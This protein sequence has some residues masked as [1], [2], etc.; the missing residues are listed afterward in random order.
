LRDALHR[1]LSRKVKFGLLHERTPGLSA[2]Y[3]SKRRAQWDGPETIRR[4]QLD[5]LNHLL[6]HAQRSSPYYARTLAGLTAIERL[7]DLADLPVLERA[8][9]Q[10]G[11]EE[12][13]VQA[14][15][16]RLHGNASGGS[17]GEPV[18]FY[19]GE[20]ALLHMRAGAYVLDEMAGWRFGAR[21][22]HLWGA[23]RDTRATPARRLNWFLRNEIWIDAFRMESEALD[24]YHAALTRA[25]PEILVAYA[26]AAALLA[27]HLRDGRLEPT[28]PTRAI[29][30][31]AEPL[32]AGTRRRIREVFHVPVFNRYGSRE[33]GP[34][35]MECSAARGMHVN[36][37][38]LV[39]EV[40][41]PGTGTPCPEGES[42]EILITSLRSL[43]FPFIRY[44]T[45][46]VGTL[47]RGRCACG[48]HTVRLA[49]VGGRITDFVITAEGRRVHGELFAHVLY[50]RTWVREFQ[51]V[52]ERDGSI[53]VRIVPR[54][55]RERDTG[56]LEE[57]IRRALDT[58]GP[59]AVE[60]VEGIDRTRSGKRRLVIGPGAGS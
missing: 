8:H 14:P 47:E 33:F 9:L 11:C 30:T 10:E 18:V 45:G 6:R 51:I 7:E 57:A 38:D 54:Q 13:R 59:V 56:E 26:S 46:D 60:V 2:A 40:V 29:I 43:D 58:S 31:S 36:E 28:Y 4:R 5:G 17:T 50:D 44:R 20:E 32:P 24:G 19:H 1:L 39:L 34:V 53:R 16:V 41:R 37:S 21:T 42:G 27:E 15:G 49:D 22:A 55:G 52:Q 48:R 3:R 35:A 23:D 25:R 12:I